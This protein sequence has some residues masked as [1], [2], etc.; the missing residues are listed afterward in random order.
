MPLGRIAAA[1][2]ALML[3]GPANPAE[4]QDGQA[5]PVSGGASPILTLNQERLYVETAWGK[6]IQAELEADSAALAAENRR[7]EAQLTAEE[8][9][10]TEA[11]PGMVPAEFRAAADAFDAKVVEI[12]KTQDQKAR[13]LTEARDKGRQSFF[14]AVLPLMTEVLSEH[15]AVAILDGRAIFLAAQSIDMTDELIALADAR[16]GDGTQAAEPKPPAAEGGN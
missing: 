1:A 16:L 11:R 13:D 3:L 7:I 12:R 9:A 6:R 5:A 4:A 2:A 14:E 10:L 15:G 8:K